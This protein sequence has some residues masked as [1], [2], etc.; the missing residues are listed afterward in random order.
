MLSEKA[1]ILFYVRRATAKG[2][3]L[4][5]NGNWTSTLADQS[6]PGLVESEEPSTKDNGP[7]KKCNISSGM[8]AVNTQEP[9]TKENGFA[10]K[11][12]CAG[13]C[14]GAQP[15]RFNIMKPVPHSQ[16]QKPLSG[17]NGRAERSLIDSGQA[18]RLAGSSVLNGSLDCFGDSKT[19]HAVFQKQEQ[20]QKHCA[21]AK[22]P[23]GV[24]NSNGSNHCELIVKNI[25]RVGQKIVSNGHNVGV[26]FTVK[27]EGTEPDSNG[28]S[29]SHGAEKVPGS[30][31][32]VSQP[33]QAIVEPLQEKASRCSIDEYKKVTKIEGRLPNGGVKRKVPNGFLV[34]QNLKENE[35]SQ[36]M[37]GEALANQHTPGKSLPAEESDLQSLKRW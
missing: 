1:Y 7:A 27:K 22:N 29:R 33:Q 5:R 4:S 3:E 8:A 6:K 15:V 13:K 32:G 2:P 28:H 10:Q 11:S 30:C 12:G 20:E 34:D 25:E 17:E 21:S 23:E 35:H 24:S 31:N 9:S 14:E 18:K 16:V 19:D 36:E 37:I 26:P